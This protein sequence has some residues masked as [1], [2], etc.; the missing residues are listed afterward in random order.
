MVPMC[1]F[2]AP[3]QENYLDSMLRVEISSTQTGVKV[4]T[5]RLQ[6]LHSGQQLTLV[7]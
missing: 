4:I 1:R 2:E 7:L 5:Q 6:R 3:V